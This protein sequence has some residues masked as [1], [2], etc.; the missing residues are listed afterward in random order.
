VSYTNFYVRL[1]VVAAS[2]QTI[3]SMSRDEL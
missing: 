3:V 2:V 1:P